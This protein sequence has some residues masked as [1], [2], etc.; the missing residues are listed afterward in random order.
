MTVPELRQVAAWLADTDIGLFELRTAHGHIRLRRHPGGG[1]FVDET[2][3]PGAGD[4]A[5]SAVAVAAP[6]ALSVIAAPS[7]GLFLHQ[8][9]LRAT[10]LAPTGTTVQ[11]GQVVGL[12]QIGALLLAV[13]APQAGVVASVLVA[14]GSPVGYGTP[15]LELQPPLAP[16]SKL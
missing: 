4:D 10:P 5:A 2:V 9:P 8:H 1:G 13:A 14:H 16:S 3:S 6:P 15:L 12:L 11:A 7:V